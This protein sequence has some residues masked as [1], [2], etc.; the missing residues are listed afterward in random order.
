MFAGIEILE[1]LKEASGHRADNYCYKK[2][3]IRNAALFKGIKY[4]QTVQPPHMIRLVRKSSTV[5][6]SSLLSQTFFME[7]GRQKIFWYCVRFSQ[8]IRL[9]HQIAIVIG[10]IKAYHQL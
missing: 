9:A 1:R 7:M 2:A 6:A 3:T 5:T 10:K 8:L 4:Y